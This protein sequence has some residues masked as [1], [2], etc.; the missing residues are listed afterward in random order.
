MNF[1]NGAAFIFSGN[2]HK[3]GFTL[4]ELE[5]EPIT[6]DWRTNLHQGNPDLKYFMDEVEPHIQKL[7]PDA[8]KIMWTHNVVRGGDKAGD[9]PKAAAPH[10]DYHQNKALRIEYHNR[11]GPPVPKWA[12]NLTEASILMG[13]WDTEDNKFGK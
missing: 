8:K 4:I 2:F 13:E 10:L 11:V 9:Q 6:K 7:Y 3:T 12:T 5:N 1:L